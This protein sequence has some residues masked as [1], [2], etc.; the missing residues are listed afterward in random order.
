MLTNDDGDSDGM[1][2]GHSMRTTE[3]DVLSRG[4]LFLHN[5]VWKKNMHRVRDECKQHA[6]DWSLCFTDYSANVKKCGAHSSV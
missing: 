1:P 3:V 4:K 6:D 2:I 5:Y